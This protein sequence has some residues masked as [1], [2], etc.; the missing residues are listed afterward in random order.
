M[1]VHIETD[2]IYLPI[3]KIGTRINFYTENSKYKIKKI[4]EPNVFILNGGSYFPKDSKVKII[5]TTFGGSMIRAKQLA[6]GVVEIYWNDKTV[7]TSWCKKVE[8]IDNT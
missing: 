6:Q 8:V 3:I 1:K 4:E 5:G 2:N 7:A